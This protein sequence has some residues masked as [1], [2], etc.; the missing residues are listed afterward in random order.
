MGLPHKTKIQGCATT[1]LLGSAPE[2]E[3]VGGKY[4]ADCQQAYTHGSITEANSKALWELSEKL[5]EGQWL[6]QRDTGSSKY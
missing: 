2:L 4:Y 1:V 5:T 6:I 3:G